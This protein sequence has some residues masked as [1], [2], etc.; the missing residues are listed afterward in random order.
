MENNPLDSKERYFGRL[1]AQSKDGDMRGRYF[2]NIILVLFFLVMI[3]TVF[4]SVRMAQS[5]MDD[6]MDV[7]EEKTNVYMVHPVDNQSRK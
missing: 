7:Y 3:L 1:R 2:M 4:F 5:P 6:M